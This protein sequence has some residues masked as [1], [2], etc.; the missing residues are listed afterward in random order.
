MRALLSI[1]LLLLALSAFGQNASRDKKPTKNDSIL[2]S[3]LRTKI[4]QNINANPDSAFVYIKKFEALSTKG[5]YAS[6]LADSDYLYAQYFR[7]IQ[8]PDSAIFYFKK[9]IASSEKS[10]YYRGLS[11]GYN[12]LCRTYYL[13]GEIEKSIEACNN[14]LKFIE[15]FDDVGNVVLADTHNALAIAYSRQNRMETAIE[16]LLIVDSI[17]KKEALREDIIAAAYQSLGNVYLELKD[18]DSAEEYY[19]KANNEFEKIPGAGTFYFN[20]T[21]VFLGQVYFHTKQLQKADNLLSKT[22][23]FFEGIKDERTVAEINNYLGLV[24]LETG[25]LEK[26]ESYF[27]NAL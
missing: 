1:F 18:Y 11:M 2:L 20:T 17:H 6:S 9:M 25:N 12:G 3:T 8:K 16:N 22:L 21:N 13:L 26:A 14:G 7:R 27:Q 10:S 15:K 24:N 4:S 5:K 19:L 23:L